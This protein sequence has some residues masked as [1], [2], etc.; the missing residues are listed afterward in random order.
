MNTIEEMFAA[1]RKNLKRIDQHASAFSSE[2]HVYRPRDSK[3]RRM[4]IA[5]RETMN[6]VCLALVT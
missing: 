2:E 1:S 6:V 5:D 4:S 3:I